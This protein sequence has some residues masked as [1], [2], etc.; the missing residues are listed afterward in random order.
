MRAA[1]E[2]ED[3]EAVRSSEDEKFERVYP[4]RI[5]KLSAIYWTPV[6]VAAEA[7]RLLVTRPGL[8]VL[9]VGCGPAKFCLVQRR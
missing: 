7:A 5:R 4:A 1:D 2:E 3:D 9:D 8:R 6:A